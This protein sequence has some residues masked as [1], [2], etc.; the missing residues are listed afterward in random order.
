M[1]APT[2]QRAVAVSPPSKQERELSVMTRNE[3]E[4]LIAEG[5]KIIIY[6]GQVLKVDFWMKHHPGG[7][8]AIQHMVGR[9]G[10]DEMT[11]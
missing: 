7:D 4:A 1:A 3:I 10:T 2:S 5:R 8:L 6:E 11:V 9:D